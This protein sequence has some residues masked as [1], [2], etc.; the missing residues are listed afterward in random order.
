[1]KKTKKEELTLTKTQLSHLID[2]TVRNLNS[3]QSYETKKGNYKF[4]LMPDPMWEDGCVPANQP[5]ETDEE[6]WDIGLVHGVFELYDFFANI[7]SMRAETPG[8]D[9]FFRFFE[10]VEINS[11][12]VGAFVKALSE[13]DEVWAQSDMEMEQEE[14]LKSKT[15]G[16]NLVDGNDT[17]N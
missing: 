17:V 5:P 15:E 9:T 3:L 2:S 10:T 7:G 1:M 6:T 16:K 14:D 12:N 4:L 8:G 11:K 13:I